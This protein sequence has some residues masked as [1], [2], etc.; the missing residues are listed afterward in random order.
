MERSMF[1]GT[2]QR[3]IHA[4]VGGPRN[5]LHQDIAVLVHGYQN[6]ILANS[7]MMKDSL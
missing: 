2:R 3:C 5:L 6:I 7:A 1:K 4:A